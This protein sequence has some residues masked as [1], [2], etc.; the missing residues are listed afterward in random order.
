MSVFF[1]LLVGVLAAIFLPHGDFFNDMEYGSQLNLVA[2]A[3]TAGWFVLGVFVASMVRF[4]GPKTE[5]VITLLGT[6]PI[7]KL[8]TGINLTLPWPIGF[9]QKVITTNVAASRVDVQIKSKDNLAF[10][11]PVTIQYRVID[12]MKYAFERENPDQQMINLSVAS[13]RSSG[14]SLD[15]QEIYNDKAQIKAF[16]VDHIRED[17]A[18]FGME[19][20]DLLIEDPKLPDSLVAAL[21]GIREAEYGRQ[22]ATHTAETTFIN[23]VGAARA[24]AESTR[25]KGQAMA[26]FRLLLAEGNAAA[27]GVMQGKVLLKWADE[28]VG[29]GED[30]KTVK[31]AKFYDP[32]DPSVELTKV[33]EVDIDSGSVLEF[34]KVI[35]SNDAIRDA[36]ANPGTVI[37]A[38]A[39]GAGNY[40][41]SNVVALQ[42]GLREATKAA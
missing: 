38:P 39:G 29:T 13:V 12:S 6:Q 40:D 10:N 31:V 37:I 11:L 3:A 33:P 20:V 26:N 27:V 16:V 19:I 5:V 1:A 23:K 14:N 8:K 42:R 7:Q 21:N 36:S 15:F 18:S 17:L 30:K 2:V 34:F 32:N 41:F 25:L 22:A 28:E 4:V 24:E 9:T 35:D